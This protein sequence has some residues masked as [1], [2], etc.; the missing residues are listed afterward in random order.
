MGGE[1][2]ENQEIQG[3]FPPFSPLPS[4]ICPFPQFGKYLVVKVDGLILPLSNSMLPPVA[5]LPR[6]AGAGGGWRGLARWGDISNILN[7]VTAGGH[8]TPHT[9]HQL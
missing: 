7:I 8:Q 6:G 4:D 3:Q 9:T 1:A 2:H 5:T